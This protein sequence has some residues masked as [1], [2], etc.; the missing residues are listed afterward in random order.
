M[1]GV[2]VKMIKE[3]AEFEHASLAYYSMPAST[4]ARAEQGRRNIHRNRN[5]R[6]RSNNRLI[7]KELKKANHVVDAGCG[8]NH[9]KQIKPNIFAFDI[10]DYGNQDCVCS[11]MD[12]PIKELSKDVVLSLGVLHECPDNYH[13]PNIQKML[14]WLKKDGKLIMRCK[15][16]PSTNKHP[17]IQNRKQQVVNF[18]KYFDQGLWPK[19]RIE[20]FTKDLNLELEWIVDNI[21]T[22]KQK[23]KHADFKPPGVD[24]IQ[25]GD[26]IVFEGYV[27]CWRKYV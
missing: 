22:R 2:G 27:W 8:G 23:W 4:S 20:K 6:L 18:A 7:V 11:I 9:F 21:Q 13:M 1:Y 12:A 3:F 15:S 16:K 26:E 17:D 24:L 19:V 5:N 14:S 25:D 10:I